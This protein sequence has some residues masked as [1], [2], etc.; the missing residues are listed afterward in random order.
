LIKRAADLE[1][2]M[3]AKTQETLQTEKA[4]YAKKVETL[5]KQLDLE[6]RKVS[7]DLEKANT[8]VHRVEEQLLSCTTKL[9]K[10]EEYRS[11]LRDIDYN[12]V[13][14]EVNKI[15][16]QCMKI[17]RKHFLS[18][19]PAKQFTS[20]PWDNLPTYLGIRG[21][22]FPPSNSEAAKQVR[23]A[24]CMHILARR[25]CEDFFKPCYIPESPTLADATQLIL[26]QQ[27]LTGVDRER[28]TR[29]LL[30]S[31]YKTEEV[32]EAINR[33]VT[34]SSKEVVELLSPIGGTEVF[35]KDVQVLFREAA[36]V[37]RDVQHGKKAVE[38]SM[39]DD[40]GDNQDWSFLPDFNTVEI[41][42]KPGAPKFGMINLFPR[43]FIHEGEHLIN[44]GYVLW[45]EQSTVVA[46]EQ[47]LRECMA[48]RFKSGS[49]RR[50]RRL[51]TRSDG[52]EGPAG[53]SPTSLKS[54]DK[55][56]LSGLQRGS[57]QGTQT[58]NGNRGDR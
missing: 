48:A 36:R 23:M 15:F 42:E 6:K 46:A 51:S 32:D 12:T 40:F 31:M 47:E 11:V 37:W 7:E 41:K 35:Q 52:R 29:A 22:D 43:V 54:E 53:S 19:L 1:K 8:K 21:L 4:A 33:T 26:A 34:D 56:A 20:P 5:N 58:Q 27:L 38:V 3:S 9:S 13:N 57:K 2:E 49:L 17:A 39:K 45:P 14:V 16:K 24:A 30:L 55:V 18:E 10:W 25:L 44:P 50:D 28:L